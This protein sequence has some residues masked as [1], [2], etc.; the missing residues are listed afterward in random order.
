M[1]MYG[2]LNPPFGQIFFS[3]TNFIISKNIVANLLSMVLFPQDIEEEECPSPDFGPPDFAPPDFAPPPL[4]ELCF[5]P[6]IPE[7]G[8]SDVVTRRASYSG[9]Y[10]IALTNI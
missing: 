5:T 2:V 10:H 6:G 9:T 7:E 8:E 4:P 1:E 3:Q